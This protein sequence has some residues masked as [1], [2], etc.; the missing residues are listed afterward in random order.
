MK[1]LLFSA[2]AGICGTGMGGLVTAVIGRRSQNTI[3]GVLSFA[4]GVMIGIVCF[5]LIP[6]ACSLSG[7]P[8]TILGLMIGIIAIMILNRLGAIS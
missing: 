6:E 4:A 5:G 1:I 2:L 7:L 3:C 8:V